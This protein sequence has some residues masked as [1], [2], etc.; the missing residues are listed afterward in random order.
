V[1][2]SVLLRANQVISFHHS[3]LLWMLSPLL[4]FLRIREQGDVF[5]WVAII[6]LQDRSCIGT[7]EAQQ[8]F[9]N[10]IISSIS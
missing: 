3:L 4:V 7:F 8:S 5:K 10:V 1:R 9:E 6:V 2:P